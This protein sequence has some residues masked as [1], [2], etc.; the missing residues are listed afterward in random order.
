MYKPRLLLT[1]FA[2]LY[3]LVIRI[4]NLLFE[5]AVLKK[6][7][8]ALPVIS[9]GNLAVGGTGKSPLTEYLVLILNSSYKLAI[10]SRGYKRKSR[11]MILADENTDARELGDE[12]FQFYRKF[13]PGVKIC[14]AEDRIFAVP[15]ILDKFPDT[16]VLLLDDAFQH[17]QVLRDINILV[18]DF[19]RPFYMDSILPAG[20]LREPRSEA[21]RA[22]LVVVTKSP[23]RIDKK[24][25]TDIRTKIQ[26]YS[27]R[28][29]PVFF[30]YIHY[31]DPVC[32]F[33]KK[34]VLSKKLIVV[35]GIANP[36]PLILKLQ[37]KHLILKHFRYP[38]HHYFSDTDIKK[39]LRIYKM[40]DMENTS[41]L[42]TEKD[43]NRI[44]GTRQEEILKSYPVF[45][46][47]ITYKFVSQEVNFDD[48]IVKKIQKIKE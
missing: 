41:I 17:R 45:F 23:F 48:F 20:N 9:V 47:P 40:S 30:S 2:W 37:E 5:Y 7:A 15:H 27:G 28:D 24:C 19:N 36:D 38:D 1:P 42:F 35:T 43:I 26:Q 22:D 11:G 4:R 12:P 31:L 33:E 29:T 34:M 10:L 46:Q 39:I 44:S 25:M 3:S 14:V 16:E 18:T 6:T 21:S 32:I 13:Y 8:F